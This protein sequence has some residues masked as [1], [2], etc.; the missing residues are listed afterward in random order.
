MLIH[1]IWGISKLVAVLANNA[2]DLQVS[3]LFLKLLKV[4]TCFLF[5]FEYFNFEY[6]FHTESSLYDKNCEHKISKMWSSSSCVQKLFF[7]PPSMAWT[8]PVRR[9]RTTS[10]CWQLLK[11]A[12]NV[13]NAKV[14]GGWLNGYWFL[15]VS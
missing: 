1:Y 5:N 12:F 4:K 8:D 6:L 2:Y 13:V 11:F 15:Y 3:I 10:F 7:S 14:F 9:F